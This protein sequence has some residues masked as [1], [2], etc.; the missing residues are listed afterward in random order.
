[1]RGGKVGFGG[2]S[3]GS[4]SSG[5]YHGSF[6]GSSMGSTP[7]RDHSGGLMGQG[8]NMDSDSFRDSVSVDI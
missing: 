7:R 5:G 4:P 3:G 1:M 2:G 6:R 8:R